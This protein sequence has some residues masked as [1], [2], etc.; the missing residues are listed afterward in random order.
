MARLSRPKLRSQ[1]LGSYVG[2]RLGVK[3]RLAIDQE[4]VDHR[5]THVALEVA[6][7]QVTEGGS[8]AAPD[9]RL[10]VLGA[11]LEHG[12]VLQPVVGQLAEGFLHALQGPEPLLDLLDLELVPAQD[13]HR[14]RAVEVDLALSLAGRIDPSDAPLATVLRRLRHTRSYCEQDRHAPAPK[15]GEL[16]GTWSERHDGARSRSRLPQEAVAPE[17][18]R[19]AIRCPKMQNPTGRN[20]WGSG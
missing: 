13:G 3:R 12:P 4:L 8:K 2:D 11:A 1:W 5:A 7:G 15:C 9:D 18:P 17:W 10:V 19:R 14:R 20:L 6:N 16:Q